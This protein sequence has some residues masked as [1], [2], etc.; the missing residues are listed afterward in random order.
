MNKN[1]CIIHYNTPTLTKC[2]VESINKHVQDVKI[3]IFDNSDKKPFKDVYDNVTVFDNTG[4]EYINFNKWLKK[5]PRRNLS[6]GKANKWG[7]AKHAYSVEKCMELIAEPFVLL[8]SDVLIKKDFSNLFNDDVC[9]VGEVVKQPRSII[10]RVLPFICFINVPLCQSKKVHYF[11]EN[12]MHGLHVGVSG[13]C[14]DTGAALYLLTEKKKAKHKEIKVA[15]YVVHYGSGSWVSA[16]V[17]MRK[18]EHVAEKTWLEK[19]KKLWQPEVENNAELDNGSCFED[20]FDHIYCLHYL[21]D[22]ERLP[23]IKSEL[24]RVGIDENAY[25]FSWVYDY[26]SPIL[27]LIFED[28]RLNIDVSLRSSGRP[29]IKRVSL[30][31][32]EIAKD[33]YENGYER[34]LVLEDDVRF[35]KSLDY[36]TKML[37]N[38]PDT[39]LVMFDKMTSSSFKDNLKYKERLRGLEDDTLYCGMAGIFFIFASC[40]SINRKAMKHIIDTQEKCLLPPDTPF[41]DDEITGSFAVVNLAIQDPAYKTRRSET[42]DNIGLDVSMYGEEKKH[43]EV[44]QVVQKIVKKASVGSKVKKTTSPNKVSFKKEPVKPRTV[45][46]IKRPAIQKNPIKLDKAKHIRTRMLYAPSKK[47]N[48]LY[49]MF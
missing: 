17:K 7:S 47:S 2:L 35:H 38:I 49:D 32:Y 3:Y 11:D 42:Y 20:S 44:K 14:Y 23:K 39:D 37:E 6:G 34:I 33:A 25:Y 31:H 12:Y 1:V 19:Y 21:P 4:G 5:Y 15:D 9:Y 24:K 48:K 16:S 10:K 22:Q 8:D 13:D 26:P 18:K 29:Y 30:K 28:K 40:Y 45:E 36:I 43:E 46:E 41:N 27:D